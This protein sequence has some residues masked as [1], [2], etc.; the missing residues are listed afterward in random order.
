M[1]VKTPPER[2]MTQRAVRAG[3]ASLATLVA[4]LAPGCS[5]FWDDITSRSPEPGVWNNV[6]FR[7]SLAFNQFDPKEVLT[8]SKDGDLRRRALGRLSEPKPG[9]ERD[10]MLA[11]LAAAAVREPDPICRVI[12]IEK[13]GAFSDSR[14]TQMLLE[15]YAAPVNNTSDTTAVRIAVL[16]SLAQRKDPAGIETIL[17]S[18]EPSK[19]RDQRMAAADAL[20]AFPNY[21]AAG[22]LV[23]I[24]REE[25]DVALRRRAYVSLQKMTGR[26]NLPPQAEAW[27]E[28]FRSAAA[29][30]AP[31]QQDNSIGF[32]LASWWYND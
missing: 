2:Q 20:A 25:K 16:K 21:H 1:T 12:A 6:K 3:W 23:T 30:G 22:G 18:L 19:P 9:P 32:R 4:V 26:E 8:T 27:E 11:I 24:L 7:C 17:A 15:A 28:V 29:T 14:C 13:L 31:I 10:E 5:Q